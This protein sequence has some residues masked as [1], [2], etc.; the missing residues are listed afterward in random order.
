[1]VSTAAEKEKKPIPTL[2][3]R[4]PWLV[5]LPT[6]IAFL[7]LNYLAW[8]T[9]VNAD[10]TDL[11]PSPTV[12]ALRA[13]RELSGYNN[14]NNNNNAFSLRLFLEDDLL[15]HLFYISRYFGG[16]DAVRVIWLLACLIH[17]AELG[18]AVRV[19][20]ACRAV[21]LVWALY[22]ILTALG[23]VSQLAP[24]LAARDAYMTAMQGND[25][26]NSNDSNS[27]KKK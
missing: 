26:N 18:I 27:E 9:T 14:N 22:L 25:N 6:C 21:P 15:R 12:L 20:A 16:M 5:F 1:M 10:G 19:C 17:C 3:Y 4:K 8:G 7:L 24:L 11:L 23:G 13:E 2:P